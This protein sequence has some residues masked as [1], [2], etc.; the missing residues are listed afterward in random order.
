MSYDLFTDI[1]LIDFL[2]K[3]IALPKEEQITCQYT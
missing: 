3:R 2:S 1:E